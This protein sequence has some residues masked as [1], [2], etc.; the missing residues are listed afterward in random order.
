MT[1]K[2]AKLAYFLFFSCFTV[3]IVLILSVYFPIG[4]WITPRIFSNNFMLSIFIGS[5]VLS[6]IPA[7]FIGLD[8]LGVDFRLRQGK[9]NYRN[10][11]PLIRIRK[12]EPKPRS[13]T[14]SDSVKELE[15]SKDSLLIEP[16]EGTKSAFAELEVDAKADNKN[17]DDKKAFFLFGETEFKGCT[18]K[19]G[20]L[21][22]LPKN[23]PIPDE[24]FGC[25]QI[26]E[27]I[28]LSGK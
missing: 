20:Y 23:K 19:M 26:L 5:A 12:S 28:A 15:T 13:K 21:K 11:L 6:S 25:P 4:T 2:Q 17:K 27:C 1:P 3:W 18:F 7:M 14:V 22:S 10:T 16:T 8:F 24:C 9:Q